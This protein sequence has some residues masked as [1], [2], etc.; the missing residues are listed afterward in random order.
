MRIAIPENNGEVN[1][2]FGQSKSF[3]I[4]KI[5]EKQNIHVLESVSAIGL[6]N[7]HEG[8]ADLL[9]K[10]EVEVV[11]VG[12]IG[13][14]AIDGLSSRGLKV[15]FGAS[16][17]VLDVAEAFAKGKFISKRSICNHHSNDAQHGCHHN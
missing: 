12:G 11:I 8:L 10:Q 9:Q 13:Q 1:Q 2:H 14:G 4:I 17:S 15:L 6:Q 5:D 16:G 7:R 3:S